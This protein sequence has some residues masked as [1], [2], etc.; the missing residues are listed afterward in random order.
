MSRFYK[1]PII[2]AKMQRLLLDPEFNFRNELTDI[3]SRNIGYLSENGKTQGAL[4][5]NE[6]WF[7]GGGF[8]LIRI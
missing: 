3:F 7:F 2:G 6:F 4:A 5:P 8:F 1:A